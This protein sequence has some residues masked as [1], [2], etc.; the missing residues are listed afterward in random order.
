MLTSYSHNRVRVTHFP[1]A[2]IVYG[3]QFV[4]GSRSDS[5]KFSLLL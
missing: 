2:G 4:V 5:G 3:S 1:S